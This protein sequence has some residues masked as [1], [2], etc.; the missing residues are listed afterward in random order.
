VSESEPG[1]FMVRKIAEQPAVLER[2]LSEGL[3]GEL[4]GDRAHQAAKSSRV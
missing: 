1:E 2:V 3:P 4:G